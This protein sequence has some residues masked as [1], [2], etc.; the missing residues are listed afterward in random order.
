V[1]ASPKVPDAQQ[2]IYLGRQYVAIWSGSHASITATQAGS[3]A[4]F[5][6]PGSGT[7]SLHVR[8]VDVNGNPMPAGTT[9]DIGGTQYKV[10]NYVL[11]V[12]QQFGTGAGQ[13]PIEE[14][15][16]SFTCATAGTSTQTIKVKTPRGIETSQSFTIL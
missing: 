11:G 14:Y 13:I 5:S 12:G 1:L 16:V 4:A 10:S 9:I 3:C 2:T 15:D 6:P 7:V 8:V